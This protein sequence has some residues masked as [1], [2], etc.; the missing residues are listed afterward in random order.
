MSISIM[1][2]VWKESPFE[3][4][5]LLVHLALADQAND[6]GYCWPAVKSIAKKCRLDERYTRKLLNQMVEQ[7]FLEKGINEGKRGTNVYL[8][9]GTPVE[10]D[11]LVKKTGGEN[12][13]AVSQDPSPLSPKTA[14]PSVEPS[15]LKNS[16]ARGTQEEIEEFCLQIGLQ[17][18]DGEWFFCKCEGNKWTNN[19]KP[20]AD[21]KQTIRSWKIAGYMNSQKG[22]GTNN[23]RMNGQSVPAPKLKSSSEAYR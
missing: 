12:R 19:G 17:K 14:E 7:G 21:W 8:V 9:R 15:V 5:L 22:I 3:H 16:K 20:I 1:T 13:Q 11:P 23:S 2:Q 4:S 10:K 6:E 18:T